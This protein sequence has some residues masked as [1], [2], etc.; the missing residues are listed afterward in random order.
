MGPRNENV[1]NGC[2][3]TRKTENKMKIQI[4]LWHQLRKRWQNIGYKVVWTG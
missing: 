3:H 1:K 4:I 2:G